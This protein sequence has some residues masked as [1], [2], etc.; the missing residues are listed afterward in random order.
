MNPPVVTLFEKYGAGG[1]YVGPRVAQALGVEWMDQAFSSADI[2]SAKYPGGGKATDQGSGL[3][4]FLGRF[5]PGATLLDDAAIPL[6]QAQ[7]AEMVQENT[8]SVKEAGA[9]GVVMLGRNGALILGDIPTALHVQL[10]APVE[11]RIARAAR[12][13]GIDE[14]HAARRQRN[15]DRVRAEM[16]ER[17]YYWNPMS[18]DRY[19]LVVNTGQFDLDTAVDV[20]VAAYRAKVARISR[21]LQ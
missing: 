5:A 11:V 1:R 6:A 16:S 4:R 14:A 18:I 3:A 20:I 13:A 19:D 7:D 12:E 15:E 10:D 17:L 8:R 2:E 9:R 21:E